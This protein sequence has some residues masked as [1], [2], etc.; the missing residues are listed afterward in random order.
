MSNFEI[1][2][3]EKKKLQYEN[4]ELVLEW[5]KNF[6]SKWQ[7]KYGQAQKIMDSEILRLCQPYIP[8]ITSLLIK[9]G[10][11]GT[12]VG[13]GIV[14]WIAIYAKRVYY[15]PNETIGRPTGHLRGKKWFERMKADKGQALI[16][17]VKKEFNV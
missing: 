10:I 5:S 4:K 3:P 13:S 14:Q 7:K 6:S 12:V 15:Q 1:T 9:S 17:S 11:I 16:Q 2:Q 8:L